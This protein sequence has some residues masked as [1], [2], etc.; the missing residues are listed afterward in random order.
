MSHS[1]KDF[2]GHI[3]IEAT[4]ILDSCQGLEKEQ[5]I[6]DPILT[7]AVVRSLEIIGEATKNLSDEFKQKYPEIPWRQMA[8]M[9]DKLIHDYFGVDYDVVWSVIDLEISSLIQKIQ[10]CI[11]EDIG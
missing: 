10:K 9:R 7:R 2:L 3:L 5:F 6:N 8:G 11:S 4:F 1:P